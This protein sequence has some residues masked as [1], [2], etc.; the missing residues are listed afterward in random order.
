MQSTRGH[1]PIEDVLAAAG[2]D[3]S[4]MEDAKSTL[5]RIQAAHSG[6]LAHAGRETSLRSMRSAV[7]RRRA[8]ASIS[9]S[10]HSPAPDASASAASHRSASTTAS[11]ER[12]RS[13]A[14]ALLTREEEDAW[15]AERQRSIERL[16]ER[17]NARRGTPS[18]P[19]SANANT[20]TMSAHGHGD[21]EGEGVG[22]G[23][24][25]YHP[26]VRVPLPAV[27]E[28]TDDGTEQEWDPPRASSSSSTDEHED[29]RTVEQHRAEAPTA[30]TGQAPSTPNYWWAAGADSE[31]CYSTASGGGE[32]Q[33]FIYMDTT[34]S[35]GGSW[36]DEEEHSVSV[37]PTTS[38][39][40]IH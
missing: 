24:G 17:K 4:A 32:D 2:V 9:L 37:A 30:V 31:S 11:S 25:V 1:A 15:M 14:L 12:R 35:E 27:G 39:L 19:G 23:A 22:V 7:L 40:F 3:L 8:V 28:V 36:K 21:D 18:R 13:A 10:R 33:D 29:A 20:N 34:D 5:L 38:Y 6:P 16:Q 26:P